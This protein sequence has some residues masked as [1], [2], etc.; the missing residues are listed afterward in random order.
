[1]WSRIPLRV[2]VRLSPV[3]VEGDELRSI[4]E[5]SAVPA[6]TINLSLKGAGLVHVDPFSHRHAAITVSLPGNDVVRLLAEVAWT[7][8]GLDGLHHS[9]TRFLGVIGD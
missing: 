9:G 7:Y 2:P 5:S 3:I 6:E 1:M 4:E 8:A